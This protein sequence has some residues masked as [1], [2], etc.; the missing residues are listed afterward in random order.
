MND[1]K[2]NT[3]QQILA[4]LLRGTEELPA[5]GYPLQEPASPELPA[6]EVQTV[7]SG[8]DVLDFGE[9]LNL[10]NF[11]VV[12]REFFAHVLEPT[13]AFYDSK[14]TVNTACI[15]KFPEAEY[16]QFLVDED[17]KL[18]ALRPCPEDKRDSFRWCNISKGK[19]KPREAKGKIFF[20]KIVHLMSWNP[21]NKY[22]VLGRLVR[23]N[24]RYMLLFDLS[25]FETYERIF[26][27][28][29]KP[30]TSKTAVFQ[31]EWKDSFGLPFHE[32]EQMMKISVFDGFAVYSVT[33]PKPQKKMAAVEPTDGKIMLKAVSSDGGV[34][35]E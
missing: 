10:E 35:D 26:K 20:A 17:K 31:A 21:N 28:G 8:E 9:S 16:V 15:S 24:G 32:H 34:R 2:T 7:L 14:L 11:Q 30:K 5:E 23:A 27:E 18:F 4:E 29:E 1:E 13:V 12:R 3:S 33:D 22:K 25:S 6:E 19:R